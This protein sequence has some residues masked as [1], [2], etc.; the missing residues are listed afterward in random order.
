MMREH[1]DPGLP[2]AEPPAQVRAAV[3]RDQLG[4]GSEMP[5]ADRRHQVRALGH[6]IRNG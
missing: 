3:E 6:G 1:Q 5:L 2:V 4:G